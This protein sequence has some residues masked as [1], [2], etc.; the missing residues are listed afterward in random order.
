MY[1]G[2]AARLLVSE[3]AET[4]GEPHEW[5]LTEGGLLAFDEPREVTLGFGERLADGEG[6]VRL[7]GHGLRPRSN[8]LGGL[9]DAQP[10][11]TRAARDACAR[12]NVESARLCP[13]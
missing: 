2:D 9:P 12:E 10:P 7:G 13:P 11:R 8:R 1:L 6:V 5:L 3:H 4:V